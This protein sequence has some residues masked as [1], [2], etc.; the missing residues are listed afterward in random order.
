MISQSSGDHGKTLRYPGVK[1]EF[2][3]IFLKND[4]TNRK[5]YCFIHI[6]ENETASVTNATANKPNSDNWL[7]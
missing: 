2:Q 5:A 7:N 4:V 1:F 3:I 6:L